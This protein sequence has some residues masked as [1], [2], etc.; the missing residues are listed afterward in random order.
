LG[1]RKRPIPALVIQGGSDKVVNPANAAVLTRQW[2]RMNASAR[3]GDDPGI[4]LRDDAESNDRSGETNGYHWTR[5][6]FGAGDSVVEELIIAELGHAWSGGSSTGTFTDERGPDAMEEIVR[7][8]T[9]HP[10][11]GSR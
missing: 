9:E 3:A 6:S 10:R 11:A 5:A 8:F 1:A 7:F 2:T 4:A